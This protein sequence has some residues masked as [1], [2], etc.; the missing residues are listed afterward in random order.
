MVSNS[1]YSFRSPTINNK[2]LI[3]S[4]SFVPSFTSCSLN[5]IPFSSSKSKLV[6]LTKKHSDS[7]ILPILHSQSSLLRE[8]S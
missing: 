5:S 3:H 1:C 8:T 6:V 4:S 2:P 7:D